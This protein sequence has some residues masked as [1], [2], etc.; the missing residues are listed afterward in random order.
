MSLLL[1]GRAVQ[2]PSQYD[3]KFKLAF[4]GAVSEYNGFGQAAFMNR[5]KIDGNVALQMYGFRVLC[6]HIGDHLLFRAPEWLHLAT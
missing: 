2:E 6:P 3:G 5:F 4:M 1:L